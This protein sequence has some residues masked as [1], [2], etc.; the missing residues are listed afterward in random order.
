V[1]RVVIAEPADADAAGIISDL[2]V[3]AGAV[4]ARRCDAGFDLLYTRPAAFP[5]SGSPRP[6][7]GGFVRIGVVSPYLMIYRHVPDDD[8]VVVLRIVHGRRRISRR[9]GDAAGR[10]A[11]ICDLRFTAP[12]PV[13][14]RKCH[15]GAAQPVDGGS[16]AWPT[17]TTA[18]TSGMEYS[19]EGRQLS[20]VSVTRNSRNTDLARSTPTRVTVFKF[21]IDL[22]MDG[23][24]PMMLRQHHHGTLD[25]VGR[26]PPHHRNTRGA[27]SDRWPKS[28][29][30]GAAIIRNASVPRFLRGTPRVG[31]APA[32]EDLPQFPRPR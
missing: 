7:L 23:S 9:H 15:G 31:G 30:E 12:R 1:A 2:D 4:V 3:K 5:E 22:P 28:S 18:S 6:A 11:M 27:D 17:G 14:A 32:K 24:L 29:I 25:A 21:A 20:A 16:A 8:L 13:E 10:A 26:R 19:R